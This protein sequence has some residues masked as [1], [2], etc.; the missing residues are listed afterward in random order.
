MTGGN[1]ASNTGGGGGG[2][3]RT[4]HGGDGA[5]GIVVVAYPTA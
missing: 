2:L 1:G 3:D 5:S 4:G